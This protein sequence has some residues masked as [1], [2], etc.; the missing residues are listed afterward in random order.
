MRTSLMRPE[1]KV[2]G[3]VCLRR[4]N[5]VN[6]PN[7]THRKIEVYKRYVSQ[8]WKLSLDKKKGLQVLYSQPFSFLIRIVLYVLCFPATAAVY[9]RRLGLLLLCWW[10]IAVPAIPVNLPGTIGLPL[11]DGHVLGIHIKWLSPCL[12]SHCCCEITMSKRV[13]TS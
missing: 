5:S 12:G 3:G 7:K 2:P 13:V 1:K 8:L 10:Y 11:H 4:Q 9:H 6:A